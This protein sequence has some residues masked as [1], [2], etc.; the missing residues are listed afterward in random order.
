MQISHV[1]FGFVTFSY[2]DIAYVGIVIMIQPESEIIKVF[3]VKMAYFFFT[4][5]PIVTLSYL[6]CGSL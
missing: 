6:L 4:N 1:L 5:V 2:L 3:L